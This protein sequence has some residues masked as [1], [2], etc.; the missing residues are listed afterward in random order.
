MT[1]V[2]LL[3]RNLLYHWARQ[4]RG[5]PRHR[6]QRRCADGGTAGRRFP[7]GDS[8]SDLAWHRL[9]WIDDAQIG[10]RFFRE[11]AALE[12]CLRAHE[13]AIIL[14]RGTA[15]FGVDGPL[16][17]QVNVIG[18]NSSFWKPAIWLGWHMDRSG[19][20]GD[21]ALWDSDKKPSRIGALGQGGFADALKAYTKATRCVSE[22]VRPASF[23][24]SRCSAD[25]TPTRRFQSA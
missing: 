24:R 15:S 11:K 10:G 9:F 20:N 12:I 1:P 22:S 3:L 17:R 13:S 25:A 7:R 18:V 21:P 6:G 8:L 5:L 4:P 14:V 2:R 23:R 19:G 16:V